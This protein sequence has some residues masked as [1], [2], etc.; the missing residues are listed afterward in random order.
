VDILHKSGENEFDDKWMRFRVPGEEA[1][2]FGECFGVH[3]LSNG[4]MRMKFFVWTWTGCV[5]LGATINGVLG[6]QL[7]LAPIGKEEEDGEWCKGDRVGN[8]KK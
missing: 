2:E 6:R 1:V 8:L 3:G 7:S 5:Y 4:Q